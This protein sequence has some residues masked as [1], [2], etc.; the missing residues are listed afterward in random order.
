MVNQHL[1]WSHYRSEGEGGGCDQVKRAGGGRRPAWYGGSEA[2][3][4]QR[5]EK[6]KENGGVVLVGQLACWAGS[7]GWAGRPLG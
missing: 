6:G 4:A 2:R 5:K 1:Q 7:V 3:P